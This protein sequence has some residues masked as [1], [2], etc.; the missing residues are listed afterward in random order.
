VP[1]AAAKTPS[2]DSSTPTELAEE[3]L[4]A[5]NPNPDDG[6]GTLLIYT[7]ITGHPFAGAGAD[8]GEGSF[9]RK[10]WTEEDEQERNRFL[11][12]QIDEELQRQQAALEGL[13]SRPS[14]QPTIDA[15]I[16]GQS[17][18]EQAKPWEAPEAPKDRELPLSV[19]EMETVT[20]L[21]GSWENEQPLVV[22]RGV[23]DADHDGIPEQIRF[24]DPET[25]VL[26]RKEE[27]S[28]FDGAL[29][30]WSTYQGANLV[31]RR[32]DSNTD[33]SVD[34]WEKYANARMTDRT[35]D[36]DHDRIADAFYQYAGGVL[37][38]ERHDLNND[39]VVD[40]R[41]AYQNLFRSYA[42]EDRDR[43]GSMDV[44]TTYGVSQ[45]KEVVVRV[46]RASTGSGAPDSIETY[47]T[48]SG[49]SILVKREEDRDG[50]GSIDVISRYKNGKLV[51]REVTN[52]DLAPL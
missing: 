42:E 41:I 34:I 25:K 15:L 48:S 38:E 20:I 11:T 50:D 24:F 16:T 1:D 4:A 10:G 2:R 36:R 30:T 3:L 7:A 8:D 6:A 37:V 28:N 17:L 46:E 21:A 45:G 12:Q 18:T 23:L 22:T 51:Q 9:G 27:D 43:D 13:Q 26:L 47:D 29:D 14:E 40:R 39:N 31:E 44:W 35:V 49:T 52:A 32:R 33:G 5:P 19:F